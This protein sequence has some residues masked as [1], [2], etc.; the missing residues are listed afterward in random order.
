MNTHIFSLRFPTGLSQDE[1]SEQYAERNNYCERG[2]LFFSFFSNKK[3]YE[4][5]PLIPIAL[6]PGLSITGR[7]KKKKGRKRRLAVQA[8]N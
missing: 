7:K 3:K 5:L 6:T 8:I 1:K 2:Q 4:S